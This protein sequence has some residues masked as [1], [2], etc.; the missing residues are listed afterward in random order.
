[1][2]ARVAMYHGADAGGIE[3]I[4]TETA[5]DFEARLADPAEGLEGVSE[6]LLLV[7]RESGRGLGI[8]LFESEEDL[9]R[10]DAELNRVPLSQGGG[11]RT[12]VEYYEV[13]LHRVQA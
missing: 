13:A 10:G 4:L 11:V 3:K 6:F 9:K 8:S 7:D 12:G 1:M 5:K 2:Y